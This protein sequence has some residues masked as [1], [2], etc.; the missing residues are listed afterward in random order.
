MAY[1]LIFPSI[2]ELESYIKTI[3]HN[4]ITTDYK[5]ISVTGHFGEDEIELAVN[6]FQA[7]HIK[8]KDS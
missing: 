1:T 4:D 7:I 8:G 5:N 3:K 6:R 2:E